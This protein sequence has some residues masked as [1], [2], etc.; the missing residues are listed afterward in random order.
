MCDVTLLSKESRSL[1]R[2]N[3]AAGVSGEGDWAKTGPCLDTACAVPF[4]LFTG[5]IHG[6]ISASPAEGEAS[7]APGKWDFSGLVALVKCGFG[8]GREGNPMKGVRICRGSAR[9]H[10]HPCS[11]LQPGVKPC[12]TLQELF[13]G[14]QAINGFV[15][16]LL[17]VSMPR[18][19]SEGL[20]TK[21]W[22]PL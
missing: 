12:W 17:F 10:C 3:S 1:F 9:T 21:A 4:S 16:C 18:F 2:A 5:G 6:A 11:C 8:A 22:L 19:F 14:F 20:K 7:P 15:A 13:P